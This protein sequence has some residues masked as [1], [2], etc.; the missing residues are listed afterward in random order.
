MLLRHTPF[1]RPRRVNLSRTDSRP[2][3]D[4]R[5][6]F[7]C[8]LQGRRKFGGTGFGEGG[9]RYESVSSLLRLAVCERSSFFV[10]T[11]KVANITNRSSK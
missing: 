6:N 3:R 7:G 10:D 4:V 5:L 8:D 2:L 11:S 9:G 1:P